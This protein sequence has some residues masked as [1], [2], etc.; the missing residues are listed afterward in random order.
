MSKNVCFFNAHPDDFNASL[1][2]ALVLSRMEDYQIHVVD[3]NRGHRGLEGYGISMEECA[4]T[5]TA[6]EEAV[7]A[8]L[9]VKPVFLP[10]IDGD[11]FA[12][13]ETCRQIEEI[14]LETK[15]EAVITHWPLDVHP[16]HVMCSAAVIR[17]VLSTHLPI[18]LYFCLQNKQSRQFPVDVYFPFDEAVMDEKCELLSLYKCQLG[19]EI[20]KRHRCEDQ[21]NGYRCRAPYAE[22]FASFQKPGFEKFFVELEQARGR[23]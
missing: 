18:E 2:L 13:R 11:S 21:F 19:S 23:S 8:R 15:P 3:F 10:E 4:A 22:V 20:A 12:S 7:C 16:D 1:G 14:L 6:E 9:G 17:S 5:R